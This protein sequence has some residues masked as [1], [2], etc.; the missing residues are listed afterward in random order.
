MRS[1]PN[2][3]V[4]TTRPMILL[5]AQPTT[6]C[7]VQHIKIEEVPPLEIRAGMDESGF[8]H[9]WEIIGVMNYIGCFVSFDSF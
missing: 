3:G 8:C 6:R 7:V 9:E 1:N 2:G 5:A 4:E